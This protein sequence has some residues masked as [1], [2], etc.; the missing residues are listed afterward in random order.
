MLQRL[1]F[2]SFEQSHT[3]Q[4]SALTA[5]IAHIDHSSSWVLVAHRCIESK[6]TLMQMGV[7]RRPWALQDS[8]RMRAIHGCKDLVEKLFHAIRTL[9]L[10]EKRT[11]RPPVPHLKAS[12]WDKANSSAVPLGTFAA[13]TEETRRHNEGGEMKDDTAVCFTGQRYY[14]RDPC[15][16]LA[17]LYLFRVA[18]FNRLQLCPVRTPSTN[19][20][21]VHPPR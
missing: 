7:T 14:G 19:T 8:S 18:H 2:S 5:L 3:D 20:S 4:L 9:A 12:R 1:T 17:D 21:E 11:D 13:R 16:F 15:L 6:Q 10:H